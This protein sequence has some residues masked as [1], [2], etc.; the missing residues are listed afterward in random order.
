MH[1]DT[2]PAFAA[3]LAPFAPAGAFTEEQLLAADRYL[4]GPARDPQFANRRSELYELR[5]QQD[6]ERVHRRVEDALERAGR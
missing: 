5:K 4:A 6:A 1:N 3:A 2:H